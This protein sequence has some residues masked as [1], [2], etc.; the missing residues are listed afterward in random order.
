MSSID[1]IGSQIDVASIVQGLMTIERQPVTIMEK[2]VTSLQSKVSA[3][4]TFNTR[5]SG[6]SDKVN[7]LLYGDTATPFLKP[8]SFSDRL[9]ESIFAKCA[10]ASS[11]EEKI[12]ATATNATS[13]GNY[14]LT[15]S[16][17]A[18]AQSSAS[19]GFAD[20]TTTK[21]GTGTIT[22]SAGEDDP[23]TI[24][25]TE[26]NN[27]LKG[28]QS[29]INDADLG[30]TATIINDGSS[31]PYKLLLVSDETGTANA[32]TVTESLTGGQAPGF[33]Q[34]QAA[35]DA[36]FVVNG[37]NIT[38]SSNTVDDVISGVS[39]TL[40]DA[41]SG[42]VTLSVKN[43]E[44]GIISAIK[45]MVT[46]YNS[47]NSFINN[48]FTY[49]STAEKSGVLAGDTTLRSVQYKLQSQMVQAVSNRFTSL[50]VAGQAGLEFN[51]DGSLSLNETKFKDALAKDYL[52]VAALFLGDGT[53]QGETTATDSRV[54]YGGKT[55]ATQAGTYAVAINS[56]AEQASAIGAQAITTLADNETLSITYGAATATVDLLQDDSLATVLSKIN[57]AFSAQGMAV[58]AVDNGSGQIKVATAAYGS[59]ET[60]TIVSNQ[61]NATGTT[62]F[63][64]SPIQASG[65]DIA[66]TIGG[67]DAV[68]SGLTL[69]GAIGQAEEGLSLS[70][71][72]TQTG[73]YGSVTVAS[74][75]EGI[76]GKSILMNLAS[77]LDGLTDSLTGP[78]KNAL[79]GL[80]NNIKGIQ[81]SIKDYEARLEK[82]E[83]LLTAE[84][85]AAD[86]ALKLLKVTQASLSASMGS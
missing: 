25:I 69:T 22:I 20:T 29:A 80:N 19:A 1:L 16:N 67:N 15:V 39:F 36:H 2:Q 4:Q 56:L 6:L 42:P 9:S 26:A 81:D 8:Y 10:V 50:S 77:L 79:D 3:Y 62:G 82:K 47:V 74:D 54:V 61:S 12:T 60:L 52:G 21:I 68:G 41:T 53:A 34:T 59:A 75:S 38:K 84:F 73:S 83:D 37:I 46:A 63:G 33:A 51:R 66:G 40:K 71:A 32:F 57:A 35:A 55:S 85:S 43:D 14:A 5:L 49:N 78:V 58:S 72:Q 31:T 13:G 27:T 18:Q 86:Q 44:E 7:T 48:Q 24:T 23:V 17:L 70:I 11:D 45:E 76:E 30:V 65:K 64:T 28:L